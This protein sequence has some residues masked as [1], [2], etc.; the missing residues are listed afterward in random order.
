MARKIALIPEELISAYQY[1]KPELRLEDEIVALLDGK[2]LA[3]DMKAKPLGQLVMKY[4][5]SVHAPPKPIPVNIENDNEP[6]DTSKTSDVI[7]EDSGGTSDPIIKDILISTPLRYKKYVPMIMEKLK[8]RNYSWNSSGELTKEDAPIKGSRIADFFAYLFRN[9]KSQIEPPHFK[10]FLAALQEIN[11]PR[12][13]IGNKD[14]LTNLDGGQPHLRS[15]EDVF[16][17]GN[18]GASSLLK[19]EFEQ[20][21]S[22]AIE[23]LR[24][25][26]TRSTTAFP[27]PSDTQSWRRSRS[28]SPMQRWLTY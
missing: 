4:Q 19:K 11:I 3:D 28:T 27:Y 25:R 9:V 14:V 1:Q 6:K 26:N 20:K 22:P 17:S 10:T 16:L 12:T 23:R 2:N 7:D 15:G 5:K 13:W 21:D 8:T 18:G 24:S